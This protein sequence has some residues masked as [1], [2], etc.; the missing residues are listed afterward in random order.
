MVSPIWLKMVCACSVIAVPLLLGICIAMLPEVLASF[1][2]PSELGQVQAIVRDLDG[3]RLFRSRP[4]RAPLPV[5]ERKDQRSKP[6][7]GASR[8]T[9][10]IDKARIR[11]KI[12][13]GKRAVP[14]TAM[15]YKIAPNNIH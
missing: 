5:H 14:E 8:T 1:D 10:T 9:V 4:E 11:L 12:T 2:N 3:K 13:L 6:P 15:R 7:M